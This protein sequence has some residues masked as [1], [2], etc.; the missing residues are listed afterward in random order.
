MLLEWL[1]MNKIYLNA[2]KTEI[3]KF[4]LIGN[5]IFHAGLNQIIS[6]NSLVTT[7]NTKFLGIYL[8]HNLNW[9][10]HIDKVVNQ[11]SSAVY[12]LRCLSTFASQDVLRLAYFGL[13][14]S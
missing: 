2:S 4:Q 13:I 12:A 11:L 6:D 14:E 8:T 3:I 7:S 1:S 5:P 9:E 10:I